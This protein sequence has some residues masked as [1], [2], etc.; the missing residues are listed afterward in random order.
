MEIRLTDNYELRRVDSLNWRL[1]ERRGVKK[2]DSKRGKRTGEVQTE[3]VALDCFPQT[4]EGACAWIL[5]NGKG[6]SRDETLTLEKAVGE[7]RAIADGLEHAVR[8]AVA[9]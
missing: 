9:R 4:V 8:K 7:L 3:R 1:Y 6:Y 5:E 2:L